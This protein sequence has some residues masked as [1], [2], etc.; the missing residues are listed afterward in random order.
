MRERESDGD[1]A[2]PSQDFPRQ[3]QEEAQNDSSRPLPR[4]SARIRAHPPEQVN[5]LILR[6]NIQEEKSKE[7]KFQVEGHEEMA[8]AA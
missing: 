3:P 7:A 2:S 5:I 4:R 1:Q 8:R 6:R